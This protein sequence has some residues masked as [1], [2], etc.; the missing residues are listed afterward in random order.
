MLL[1]DSRTS[2]ASTAKVACAQLA[3]GHL[4]SVTNLGELEPRLLCLCCWGN[5]HTLWM[6]TLKEGSGVKILI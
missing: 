1:A 5:S 6:Q 4:H 2:T 3:R